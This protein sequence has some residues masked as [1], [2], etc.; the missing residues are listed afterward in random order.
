M[1]KTLLLTIMLLSAV[2]GGTAWGQ[3]QLNEGFDGEEFPPTDWTTIHVSGEPEWKRYTPIHYGDD[4]ASATVWRG[5]E[6]TENYL[7]TPLLV[8]QEGESLSFYV[9]AQSWPGT[10][11]YVKLSTTTPTV[12][13][14]ST[15]LATYT[16]GSEGTIGTTNDENFVNHVVSLTGYEGQHIYLA[17]HVYED[18]G[19][20]IYLD[21]ISGVTKYVP[22]CPRPINLDCNLFSS[23]SATLEWKETGSADNWQLEICTN[24]NFSSDVITIT[25]GFIDDGENNISYTKTGLTAETIYYARV[26]S[27]CDPGNDESVYSDVISFKPYCPEPTFLTCTGYTATT[28]SFDWI[29]NGWAENWKLQICTNSDFSSNVIEITNGFSVE[30]N[31]LISCTKS[32][33]ETGTTYYARV[34][35]IRNPGT[36][37]SVYSNVISF[38][39]NLAVTI[40]DG[41][42][43]DYHAPT[44]PRAINEYQKTEIILPASITGLSTLINKSITQ[45]TFYIAKTMYYSWG[46]ARFRIFMK[47]IDDTKFDYGYPDFYGT[48]GATI[49]YEGALDGTQTTMVVELSNEYTYMG[50]NLFIGIYEIETNDDYNFPKESFYGISSTRGTLYA[51]DYYSLNNIVDG[52]TYDFL[53]KITFNYS[54]YSKPINLSFVDVTD[55]TALMSW[56]KPDGAAPIKYTYQYK[57]AS[58]EYTDLAETTALSVGLSE[59][60]AETIYTFRVKAI[61]D[62]GESSFAQIEFTTGSACPVPSDLQVSNIT[63]NSATVSW[64]AYNSPTYTVAFRESPNKTILYEGF[65]TTNNNELPSGWS[66]ENDENNYEDNVWFVGTGD[67]HQEVAATGY[68]NAKISQNSSGDI[69]YLVM[70]S[71][72]LSGKS[73]V[74]LTCNYINRDWGGDY[75]LLG[76]YYRIGND[77]DWNQLYEDDEAHDNWTY[78]EI[79]LTGLNA[80]YQIGFKYTDGYGYGVGLDDVS[81]IEIIDSEWNETTYSA[82]ALTPLIITELK[83][84][85]KYEVKVKSNCGGIYSQV[86]SFTTL[87]PIYWNEDDSW[88]S[89]DVPESTDN[90]TI[91]KDITI[92]SGYVAQANVI[93]IDGGSLTIEDGGQLIASNSVAATVKKTITD[94]TKAEDYGHWYTISTPVRKDATDNVVI[95]ETNLTTMGYDMFYFDEAQGMWINQ[96]TSG[97]GFS[98]MYVGKGYLYRNDGTDL[99]ITGNTNSGD[100]EYTLTKDGS[101]DIAGFN[102]IGNPYPH[103]INL[104]HIT[105]SKGENLNGCYILSDAGAWGS[106]LDG[107]ATISSY[108]GFLVQADVDDKVAT[109]HETAQR[110]AKSNGDNIKFMVA[111]SQYEDVAYALFDKG[112]GL[113][114][115]NHRNAA[116]PMLYINQEDADYAIATMSDD[117]KSFNLN[118]K[119]M[120]TGKYTLSYKADGNFSYLHVIDRLTGEDVDMLLEGE[121]SFIASPIDSENRFIVRLEYSAGSEI[122]ESSVFAYQSGN[123]IIVNG[124]GELQIFDMMGRRVLTQ[125]VSGVETINLQLN[126]VYIFKLNEKTQKIVVR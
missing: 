26:K 123:D 25:D 49:V 126:G 69:T 32:D 101:G 92:P 30:G 56:N 13:A 59:L 42:V 102:L 112:F 73:N 41:K 57:A 38:I 108:Q 48:E 62:G 79:T 61:Y 31:G 12:G 80:N 103:D 9:S 94:P 50:G 88:D 28:A 44:S 106:E 81:I 122:S 16:T 77:G 55:N 99:V 76:V 115:I 23:T 3:N 87:S 110:G 95:G 84:N 78:A 45:L 39:P 117:T 89:G 64:Y 93:T 124:E 21:N 90:V 75:D 29:E 85:T 71:L 20:N 35:S 113:S 1:K 114:K 36:D 58:G 5:G 51:S 34:M 17:F 14:F 40:N 27:I 86:L 19:S 91:N 65:E 109:F 11:L 10:T 104:K 67:D 6:V 96:K 83:E 66:Y 72:N 63:A 43:T 54:N 18:D 82:V 60:T 68:K 53:P 116:I 37:E 120:T 119:A 118:F 46:D 121:Y 15:T 100:I 97:T 52:V 22:T 7:I 24:E 70:P 2:F 4:G 98:N 47:E 125:Y 74:K 33:L 8:P 111:N 105:Y 107:D